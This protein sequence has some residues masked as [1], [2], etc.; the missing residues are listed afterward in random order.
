VTLA[1]YPP[2]YQALGSQLTVSISPLGLVELSDEEFEVHGPRLARYARNWAFYLGFHWVHRRE[3]GESQLTFN[4]VQALADYINHFTFG[5]GVYFK[6]PKKYS[7]IVPALLSRVWEVDNNKALVLKEIGQQGSV[8]GD[9]FVKVAYD[10][11]YQD[12]AGNWHPGRV[13]I[14]PLASSQCF[15]EWHPHDGERLVRF[16]LKYRFWTTTLEGTRQVFTY[17]E[18]LTDEKIEEYIND[19][20]IDSRPN[21][22]GMIPIVHIPNIKISGSPW[23]LSD[24]ENV[25]P[26]NREYNEKATEISDIINYHSAPVTVVTGAKPDNLIRSPRQIWAIPSTEAKVYNLENA[27]D[28]GYPLEFLDRLK[29]AMHEMTGVPETALGQIQP[30]SNTSGVALAI[31][32]GPLVARREM[33]IPT[34]SAGIQKINELILRTL[35]HFEPETLKYDPETSGIIEEGQPLEVDPVDPVAYQTECHWPPPLPVDKLVKLNELQMKMD[36]G[37]ESR[38]GALEELGNE[39]PDE[40]ANEIFEE[41]RKD[42]LENGALEMLNALIDRAIVQSTGISMQNGNAGEPSSG[43]NSGSTVPAPEN[44]VANQATVAS[45]IEREIY[46]ELVT[47]AFGYKQPSRRNPD[48]ETA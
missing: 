31:Q 44:P 29:R 7:H 36:L 19:E 11:P 48:N 33:K 46:T 1:F 9:A 13:R 39:F 4:Y 15:P 43:T 12:P 34:Y 26:I 10:P 16:K 5:K 22:L 20:L 45:G 8:T 27:V 40:K 35:W 38:R 30:I 17:T 18:I 41:R 37:L 47:Q 14:L 24:I 28:L 21:P 32:Y 2:T 25:L 23:G 42:V 3:F 6:C